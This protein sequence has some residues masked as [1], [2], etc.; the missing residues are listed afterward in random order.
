MLSVFELYKIVGAWCDEV[1]GT[2][3]VESKT[4]GDGEGMRSFYY[5]CLGDDPDCYVDIG[6]KMNGV[7]TCTSIWSNNTDNVHIQL[8]RD[9][10]VRWND[11]DTYYAE[12]CGEEEIKKL[13]EII[14]HIVISRNNEE[15]GIDKKEQFTR[16][17]LIMGEWLKDII[18]NAFRNDGY[19]N[20]TTDKNH[21]QWEICK[22]SNCPGLSRLYVGASLRDDG[23]IVV[24][25][26]SGDNV[27]ISFSPDNIVRFHADSEFN[28][29]FSREFMNQLS[30]NI[31][32]AFKCEI[33][34]YW[35]KDS[36]DEESVEEKQYAIIDDELAVAT[37]DK[38]WMK[39]DGKFD[40]PIDP[41][42]M[43][44]IFDVDKFEEGYPYVLK[45]LENGKMGIVTLHCKS[46]DSLCFN[47]W[48][49]NGEDAVMSYSV[50]EFQGAFEL[51][52]INE[53]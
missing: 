1:F 14:Q 25:T 34:D 22:S 36:G 32:E 3:D 20:L 27:N 7:E 29:D 23:T 6:V 11:T 17:Q 10:S 28:K 26:G 24:W 30:I 37:E 8:F 52:K 46:A 38:T 45:N 15:R 43:V 53:L 48:D 16:L 42:K 40:K 9:G 5:H 31:H 49:D 13:Y 12:F 39:P 4:S 21:F 35:F 41:F 44:P 51:Y 50:S 2:H 18:D 19:A 33:N 47:Y